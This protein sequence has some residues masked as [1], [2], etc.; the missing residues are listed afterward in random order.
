MD[1]IVENFA[2]KLG[3]K[4]NAAKQ[5]LSITSKYFLKFQNQARYQVFFHIIIKLSKKLRYR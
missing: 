3:T 1:D 4:P 5:S 2:E